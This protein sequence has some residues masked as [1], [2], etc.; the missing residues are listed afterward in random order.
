MEFPINHI[1]SK[2]TGEIQVE[3]GPVLLPAAWVPE[4]AAHRIGPL[5]C[6]V[7]FRRTF[8]LELLAFGNSAVQV[9]SRSFNQFG[10]ITDVSIELWGRAAPAGP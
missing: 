7:F 10:R 2:A 8:D 1:N 4:L 6:Y 9:P 3:T 5:L